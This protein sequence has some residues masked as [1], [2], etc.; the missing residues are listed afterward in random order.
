M[1]K[2]IISFSNKTEGT[3][4][5]ASSYRTTSDNLALSLDCLTKGSFF[6]TGHQ[7]CVLIPPK[8][9]PNTLRD[10]YLCRIF[11]LEDGSHIA[12]IQSNIS[13]TSTTFAF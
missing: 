13:D 7:V 4:S 8:V 9:S 6:V 12:D 2:A 3:F 5:T 11:S 10:R 1:L